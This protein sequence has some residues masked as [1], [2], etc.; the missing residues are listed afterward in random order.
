MEPIGTTLAVDT[1]R[2]YALSAQPDAPVV[3]DNAPEPGA[4]R[5][6]SPGLVRRAAATGLRR[7]ADRLEPGHAV[8]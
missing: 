3:P 6:P 5:Q 8:R 1:M 4:G 2:R 7:L